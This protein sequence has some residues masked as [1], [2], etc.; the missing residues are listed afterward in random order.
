M[1]Q[2]V[3]SVWKLII[4]DYRNEYKEGGKK[5]EVDWVKRIVSKQEKSKKKNKSVQQKFKKKLTEKFKKKSGS[6]KSTDLFYNEYT[7]GYSRYKTMN[8]RL[9][10]AVEAC[11]DSI[12]A[13]Y[14]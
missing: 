12:W 9:R 5:H 13:V 11:L 4:E 8:N 3:A 10:E 6:I 2:A 14:D 1:R 7:D